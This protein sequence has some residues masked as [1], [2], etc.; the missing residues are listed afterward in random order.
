MDQGGFAIGVWDVC[1]AIKPLAVKHGSSDK[2]WK[3]LCN[4]TPVRP[5]HDK[6]K[7]VLGA[8]GRGQHTRDMA[9]KFDAMPSCSLSRFCIRWIAGHCMKTR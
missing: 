6:N 5:F 9:I 8:K 2:L 1:S 7:I 3:T 4:F